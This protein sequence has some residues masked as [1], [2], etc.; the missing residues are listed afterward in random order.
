[1]SAPYRIGRPAGASF[2]AGGSASSLL[3]VSRVRWAR[4]RT[5][6]EGVQADVAVAGG[7]SAS[8]GSWDQIER[9]LGRA[10][11]QA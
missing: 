6:S 7:A 8:T 9:L 2:R 11:G 5:I 10:A 1:M 4:Q 3:T